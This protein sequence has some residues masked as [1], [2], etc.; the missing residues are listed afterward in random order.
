MRDVTILIKTFERPGSLRRLLKSIHGAGHAGPVLIADDSRAP[1]AEAA[2][3][4]FPDLIAGFVALPF[5]SGVSAGR[6]AL[7][8]I[9]R[10]PYFVLCDDDFVFDERTDLTRMRRLLDESGLDLL[11]GECYDVAPFSGG[12]LARSLIRLD[13]LRCL[14][15]LGVEVPRD[16]HS[17]FTPTGTGAIRVVPAPYVPPVISCDFVCN[18]FIARTDRFLATVGGWDDRKVAEHRAFFL[19]AKERGLKVGFT[20]EVGV[21][22]FRDLPGEYVEQRSRNK[23]LPP[24]GFAVPGVFDRASAALAG[25]GRTYRHY[26]LGRR[27][28][29]QS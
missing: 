18:F 14:A 17:N 9:V 22:H 25:L 16:I 24:E 26:R 21:T 10:T 27:P 20:A 29:S 8:P 5:N 23:R 7:L 1:S 6:N 12:D 19:K 3:S 4:E 2:Q 15:M 28:S 13:W 11:G